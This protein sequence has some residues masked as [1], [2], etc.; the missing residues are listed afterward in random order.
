MR[1]E[2]RQVLSGWNDTRCDGAA[3]D[4][5][6]VVRGAGGGVPGCGRG[7]VRGWACVV[8]RE[9]DGRANRLARVLAGRGAG[10]ESVVAVVM[11]RSAELVVALLA[12][13]KAGAA[14]LPVDPGYPAAR[15]GF[16]LA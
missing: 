15:I 9:L 10:P 14:Y 13:L 7:G 12:V 5:A 16:M 1:A 4:V 11:D 6:G 8:T 2:R 3:G